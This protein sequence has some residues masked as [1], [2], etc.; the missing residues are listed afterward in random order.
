MNLTEKIKTLPQ[1]P[2][3]Y[4]FLNKDNEI[5][6]IG[7]SKNLRSRVRSY[8]TGTKEGKIARLVCQIHDLEI[9]CCDTHLEA[10]LLECQRIKEIRPP[11]NAQFKRE[12]SFVYLKLGQN[13]KGNAVTVVTDP[14][15]GFGPFRNRR[16]LESILNDFQ[17][18]F[19][20][21]LPAGR[22]SGGRSGAAKISF[23]YSALPRRLDPLEFDQNRA[24]LSRLFLEEACWRVFLRA[25]QRTMLEAAGQEHFQQA[26][27]FRD[28]KAR[29][30]LLQ[31]FWF[32]DKQ[33]FSQRLFLRIPV[34]N[35]VKFFRVF[36][37]CIEDEAWGQDLTGLEFEDFCLKSGCRLVSPWSRYPERTRFDFT[38]ILYSEIR[39]LPPEQVIL[40]SKPS[41]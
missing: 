16:L 13:P 41:V 4:R 14:T 32:E 2:G 36:N 7:K 26:I 34:E 6:Y 19:P 37:G 1:Q 10:R 25:L 5:L 23:T 24:A 30:E 18:L 40:D 35:G 22:K 29:L 12:R 27:F 39:S 20:L 3:V 28:F 9:E 15:Q 38:D 17:K 31:R 11:Y 33:L 8:F 21:Q